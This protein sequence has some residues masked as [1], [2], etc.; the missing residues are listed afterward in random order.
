ML[1]TLLRMLSVMALTSVACGPL[2]FDGCGGTAELCLARTAVTPFC[3]AG[4]ALA[5]EEALMLP[6]LSSTPAMAA[7]VRCLRSAGRSASTVGLASRSTYKGCRPIPL[8]N[9]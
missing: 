7:S 9:T 4:S 3:W 2:C 5:A 8:R 1:L 6:E